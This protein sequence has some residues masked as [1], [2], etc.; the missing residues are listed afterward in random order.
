[1]ALAYG[2]GIVA[3]MGIARVSPL[4]THATKKFHKCTQNK[5]PPA[6]AESGRLKK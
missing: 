2:P 3:F 4:Y 6:A 5:T 1:V